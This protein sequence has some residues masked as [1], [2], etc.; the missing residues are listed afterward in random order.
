MLLLVIRSHTVTSILVKVLLQSRR[1]PENDDVELVLNLA[2]NKPEQRNPR[3]GFACASAHA[4]T[5]GLHSNA[6]PIIIWRAGGG[7]GIRTHGE[8]APT[9]VFKT[10]ALNH[11][12]TPPCT[13]CSLPGR[14][15]ANTGNGARQVSADIKVRHGTRSAPYIR[16]RSWAQGLSTRI[17]EPSPV[18]FRSAV[19]CPPDVWQNACRQSH[20]D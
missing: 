6:Y 4:R 16:Q 14:H 12:A 3:P 20:R 11:S 10:G 17:A 7:G 18:R 2:A 8:L 13:A 9:P 5:V 1:R 15:S 19:P